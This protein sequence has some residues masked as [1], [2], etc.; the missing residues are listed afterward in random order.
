MGKIAAAFFSLKAWVFSRFPR[1]W[2]TGLGDALGVALRTLRFRRKVIR[3]NLEIAY[4]DDLAA[5]ERLERAAFR[6][7]GNLFLEIF[8]VLVPGQV[9]GRFLGRWSELRGQEHWRAAL[10]RGKGAIFLSS[11]VGNWEIMAGTGATHG[12]DL[13]IVTKHLKPEWLHRAIERG[14]ARYGVKGTYEPRTMKDILRFLR[15][16]KTIGIVLDQY[17]GPPLGVRV[18]FFGRPVGTS[19]A[20]AALHKRTEAP[21]L[22]VVNYRLPNG[23]FVVEIFPALAWISDENSFRELALNTARYAEV[24]EQHV[25]A[26]P[27]Q[28]LWSHRRFKGDLSPLKPGEWDSARGRH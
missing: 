6:H 24:V 11:H 18:P 23:R 25:R 13:M 9:M 1:S 4:G 5:R 14:R 16:G 10:A 15:D 19:S 20:L 17:A 12:I 7:I 26:H 3:Q 28:W 8:L 22:P 27:E 2:Q 21:I